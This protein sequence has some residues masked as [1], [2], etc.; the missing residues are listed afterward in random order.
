MKLFSHILLAI[1]TAGCG[2]HMY[3]M[4]S[5]DNRVFDILMAGSQAVWSSLVCWHVFSGRSTYKQEVD[6]VRRERDYAVAQVLQLQKRIVELRLAS[7]RRSTSTSKEKL[8]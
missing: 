4:Y 6:E 1:I 5:G 7:D 2:V 8:T 3:N